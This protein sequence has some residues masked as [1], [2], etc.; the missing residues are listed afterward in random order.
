MSARLL[1]WAARSAVNCAWL[2]LVGSPTL[3][4]AHWQCLSNVIVAGPVA[5]TCVVAA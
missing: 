3:L 1:L 4:G 2:N 5:L